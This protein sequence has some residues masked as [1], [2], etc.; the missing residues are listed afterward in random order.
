M[1]VGDLNPSDNLISFVIFLHVFVKFFFFFY[2][3][4]V[5][6]L[7]IYLFQ[8][9]Q[10]GGRLEIVPCSRVGHVYRRQSPISFPNGVDQTTTRNALRLAEVSLKWWHILMSAGAST[11]HS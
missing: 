8:I 4:F 7:S 9:W 10:C 2:K 6:S 1:G 5:S 11:I 3:V